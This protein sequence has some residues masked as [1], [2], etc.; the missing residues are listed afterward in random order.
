MI[1]HSDVDTFVP[2]EQIQQFLLFKFHG[3]WMSDNHVIASTASVCILMP[4]ML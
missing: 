3:Q 4:V 2:R 1:K